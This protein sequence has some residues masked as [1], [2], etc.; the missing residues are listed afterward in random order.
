MIANPS[1]GQQQDRGNEEFDPSIINSSPILQHDTDA[2][3]RRLNHALSALHKKSDEI[4]ALQ[5]ALTFEREKASK[6]EAEAKAAG[7]SPGVTTQEGTASRAEPVGA[8]QTHPAVSEL[9]EMMVKCNQEHEVWEA[10]RHKWEE[11]IASLTTERDRLKT[12]ARVADELRASW[13]A[14]RAAFQRECERWEN[15]CKKLGL[16]VTE[17]LGERKIWSEE[18]DRL[19]AQITS[20]TDTGGALKAER[21]Q[22][23]QEHKAIVAERAAWAS[24]RESWAHHQAASARER[25][26]WDVH[27]EAM[28]LQSAK[29]EADRAEWLC[30]KEL[31]ESERER[32]S[33]ERVT[34]I[35]AREALLVDVTRL[36][37]SLE[38]ITRS[39]NLAEKDRDFFRDQYAQASGFVSA[40]RAENVELE[41]K[42]KIAEGQARDGVA[43]IKNMYESQ[44][45]ALKEDVDRWRSVSILLQEKDRR[46]DDLIRQ[47]A[48]EQPELAERC[49]QLEYQVD[50]LHA[51]LIELGRAHQKSSVKLDKFQDPKLFGLRKPNQ[52][53]DLHL[54]ELTYAELEPG[55]IIELNDLPDP[56]TSSLNQVDALGA[57]VSP[58]EAEEDECGLY[59]C[60]W[61][62]GTDIIDQCQQSFDCREDL[63]RH[64]HDHH[65]RHQLEAV[66]RV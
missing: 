1:Q 45:K 35:E 34:M 19:T 53:L 57:D 36:N 62:S 27:R 6:L 56:D 44:I 8:T 15:E 49:R 13:D 31:W 52:T 26:L 23:E 24:E 61:K 10:E 46:T 5:R 7:Q 59:P 54:V 37:S 41:Q 50:S 11:E 30:G 38:A 60:K 47:R 43:L 18:R 40:T 22:R 58:E 21:A 63:D 28:E 9:A 17:T 64:M 39:K 16:Q 29:W 20:L 48:A 66:S 32:C 14:D 2:T 25:D 3:V 4:Q 55:E 65:Y 33:A 42:A 12:D 51:N